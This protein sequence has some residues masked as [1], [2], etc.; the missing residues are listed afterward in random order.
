MVFEVAV[1]IF[2]QLFVSGNIPFDFAADGRRQF[3]Q[4]GAFLRLR[5]AGIIHPIECSPGAKKPKA[6]GTLGNERPDTK[7]S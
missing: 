6:A 2:D 5:F 4:S 1:E 7:S 3:C